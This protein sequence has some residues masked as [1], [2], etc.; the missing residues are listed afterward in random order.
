MPARLRP[1]PQLWPQLEVVAVPAKAVEPWLE[2]EVTDPPVATAVLAKPAEPWPG[3]E[4]TD[5]PVA[6]AVPAEP[7]PGVEVTDPPVVD[8]EPTSVGSRMAVKIAAQFVARV[9]ARNRTIVSRG[10]C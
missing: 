3:V 4:V 5:P 9:A 8:A 7:R 6:A 1:F 2:V 10:S